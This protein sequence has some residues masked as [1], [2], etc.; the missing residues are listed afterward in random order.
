MAIL[1]P[2][3]RSLQSHLLEYFIIV[4]R[5][6]HRLLNFT[7]KSALKQF[8]STLSDS[9]LKSFQSEL[10]NRA[11]AIKEE[12]SLLMAKDIHEI[13][14]IRALLLRDSE[15]ASRQRKL[16]TKLRVLDACSRYKHQTTWNQTRK[17]GTTSLFHQN[18]EYQNWKGRADSCSLIYTGKLGSGKSVLLANIVEDLNISIQDKSTPVAYFFCRHDIQESSKA[19]TIIGSL[20]RQLLDPIQDLTTA[21]EFLD[22]AILDLDLEDLLNLLSH[23]LPPN[24]NAYFIL[25]GLDEC[26]ITERNTV[27]EQLRRLQEAFTLRLCVS[28]RLEAAN[29]PT[30]DSEQQQL[31]ATKTISIPNDHPEINSFLLS[32]LESRVESGRLKLGNPALV[33]EIHNALSK[34]VQGMFLWA[35]LQLESICNM[36]TD[37]A[38]R[39]A[40]NNLPKDLPQTYSRILR[41]SRENEE[42]ENSYQRQVLELV[43]AARRPLTTEELREA[44]SV[45]PGNTTWRPSNLLNDI[46]STLACC[47][48]LVIVDE[49]ELTVR[50][51]HHSFKQYL[52]SKLND[53]TEFE[54]TIDH[55]HRTMADIIVTYLNYGVFGT[56]LSTIVAPKLNPGLAPSQIIQSTLPS[57]S[58]VRQLTLKILKSM[59]KPD[60]NIGKMILDAG[61][62]YSTGLADNMHFHLYAKSYCLEHTLC[63]LKQEPIMYRL[64]TRLLKENVVNMGEIDNDGG[65]LLWGAMLKKHAAMVRAVLESGRVSPNSKDAGGLTPLSWAAQNGHEAIAKLLLEAKADIESKDSAFGRTPLLWA[66]MK[67]HEA[68]VKLLLEAKANIESKDDNYGQTPLSWAAEKGHEAIVRLLLET[69]KADI[70]SKDD[71]YGQTPLSWAAGKGHE[72]IV[73]LLLETGKADIDSKDVASRTPLSWAA[74]KGHEAIVRLLLETGKAD[75]DSK[76]AASQTPLSWA[77]GKGHEAIVRLLLETGKADID[78]K[79]S[80]SRTPLSWAAENGHEAVVKVLLEAKANK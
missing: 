24:S 10:E 37:E 75:I 56:Q 78:S 5:L 13:T 41:K 65:M 58:T 50:L 79:D 76:D 47:G 53:S 62:F 17:I 40:L 44:L 71:N 61:D 34:G 29:F 80:V 52:V 67:G 8:A 32:E 38:I 19:R 27:I 63:A 9:N 68:I 22:K 73:R 33:I 70:D 30:L 6:C 77:A 23:T 35:A 36:K 72:A 26:E 2:Q 69:G 64:L 21:V 15:S 31:I 55:A 43:T 4:V 48:G 54:F 3:S 11:N 59:K 74:G 20:A 16:K 1:Y 49:E 60:T 51:V 25:D 57:S 42:K 14:G 18:V 7:Q 45:V 28:L 66:I 39:Q 12:V 46:L